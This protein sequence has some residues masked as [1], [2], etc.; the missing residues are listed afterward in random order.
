MPI[1]MHYEG[2][3]GPVTGKYKGWIALQSCQLGVHRNVTSPSGRGTNR[4]AS[5]PSVQE[6]VVTKLQDSASTHLFRESLAGQGKKVTIDFVNPDG[7]L[8]MS[9]ELENT[10][11]TSY[12]TS[13]YG[14][15]RAMESLSLHCIKISFSSKPTASSQDS[16]Q[17][18]DH[19]MWSW[20]TQFDR[21][22]W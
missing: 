21:V 6:I 4:E 19:A 16:K 1:Y 15:D 7:S 12:S 13:G 17:V 22:P 3:A 20:A 11:I 10:L 18:K 2:I 5:A 9:L 8:S 14:G